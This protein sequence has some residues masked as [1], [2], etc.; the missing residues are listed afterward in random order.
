MARIIP[1]WEMG[2]WEVGEQV[3][4][5]E[6]CINNCPG[7]E[8]SLTI[9]LTLYKQDL[10]WLILTW[11]SLSVGFNGTLHQIPEQTHGVLPLLSLV[12]L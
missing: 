12:S 3:K 7:A 2:G 11:G 6:K 4:F 8:D 5:G 10:S 1:M 9:S